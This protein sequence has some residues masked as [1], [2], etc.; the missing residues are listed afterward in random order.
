MPRRQS[1]E[2]NLNNSNDLNPRKKMNKQENNKNI[3]TCPICFDL[4]SE[5]TITRCGHTF[6][7]KC[8]Q[9]S[10][11]INKQCPRCNAQISEDQTF[12]NF[13][14]NE[15][16]SKYLMEQVSYDINAYKHSYQYA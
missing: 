14:L 2:R 5:A 12:P 6:C 13:L 8:I 4:I 11:D 1:L 9:K 15:L 7:H 16:I 10:I 3:Y